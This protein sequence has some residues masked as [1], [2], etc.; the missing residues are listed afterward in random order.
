MV[1]L[2]WKWNQGNQ[3]KLEGE[4]VYGPVYNAFTSHLEVILGNNLTS[5]M[6]S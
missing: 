6:E 1:F 2:L 5:S 4:G 3:M